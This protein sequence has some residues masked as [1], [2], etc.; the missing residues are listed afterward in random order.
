M[1]AGC[2]PGIDQVTVP[3][4]KEGEA[5]VTVTDDEWVHI[6]GGHIIEYWPG[7]DIVGN[8]GH[9][10][11]WRTAGWSAILQDGSPLADTTGV[12]Q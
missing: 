12:G 1:S 2:V 3:E 4:A 5:V 11:P 9:G 7:K 6:G 8:K 10:L